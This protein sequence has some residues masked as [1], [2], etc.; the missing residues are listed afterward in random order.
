MGS[1]IRF[2]ANGGTH[3]GYLAPAAAGKGPGVVVLQEWWGL[4]PHIEDVAERFAAAGF[5]ALAP[6]LYNG[7]TANGPDEAGRLMQA[8]N[9]AETEKVL[10]GA[11]ETLLAH[12]TCASPNVA[13]VGYCMGGQ[14]ALLAGALNPK[15]AAVAD[16]YGIHP[17]VTVDFSR[18]GAPV[19]GIFAENDEFVG[20]E[21]VAGLQAALAAAGKQMTVH[22]YPGTDHAFFNDS[23]PDVYNAEAARDAWDKTLAFFNQHLK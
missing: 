9:I 20:R 10:R 22:T 7:R 19:L 3:N 17:A 16:Y 11:I 1:M 5:T 13:V 4:V 21:A 14:L 8:L 23:R 18:L 15:V 12:D 2:T 6:D